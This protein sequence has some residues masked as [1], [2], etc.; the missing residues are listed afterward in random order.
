MKRRWNVSLW[1]GFL[2]TL[3]APV[4]YLGV[5][6][7]FPV[8]RDFPW[9]TLLIFGA[10]LTLIFRGLA[11]AYREPGLYRGK[12]AGPILMSLGLGLLALFAFGTFYLPRQLPPSEGAPRAG[13][14]APDFTL[15]DADGR[16]V[17]LS[18]L[19]G[20]GAGGAGTASG[21]R[22]VAISVDP[23]EINREHC[24]KQ[25]YTYTFLS[26]SKAEVIRRYDLLHAGAGPGGSDVSRPAEFLIDSTGT[27]RWVNLTESYVV[28]ARPD[29]ILKAVDDLGLAPRPRDR[30][31]RIV[32][33]LPAPVLIGA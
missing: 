8:T 19:L 14:K 6:V 22:L 28:R 23:P 24:R 2:V 3:T 31:R 10:G 16:P 32:D 30:A 12:I 29:R 27:V 17:A 13:H 18:E 1:A 7:R 9:A 5:F 4:T 21:V 11:R 15:P 20:S 25:G 33:T 26:D